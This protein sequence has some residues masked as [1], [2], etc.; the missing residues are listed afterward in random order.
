[1]QYKGERVYFGSQ[2]QGRIHHVREVKADHDA[3]GNIEFTIMKQSNECQFSVYLA[4]YIVWDLSL[5]NVPLRMDRPSHFNH[6]NQIF[7]TCLES[8]LLGDSWSYNFG[9]LG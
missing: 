2:L 8:S 4:L 7:D 6:P 3:A 9:K 5:G 1:M